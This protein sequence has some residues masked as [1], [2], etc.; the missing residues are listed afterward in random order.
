MAKYAAANMSPVERLSPEAVAALRA[1]HWRGN[2]RELENCMHRAVLLADGDT[3][4]ACHVRLNASGPRSTR[5]GDGTDGDAGATTVGEG[6][7]ATAAGAVGRT[8]A[9]VERDLIL[10]TLDHTLGNR[11]HAATILGISI[12]TLRNKLKQYAD[13]GARVRPAHE[14]V[15]GGVR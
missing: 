15:T 13:E 11:T 9:E 10:H 14:P 8:V 5:S 2:V 4:E 3:I 6:A 12:R 7:A 1:H